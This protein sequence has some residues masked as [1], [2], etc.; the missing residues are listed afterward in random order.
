[1][2]IKYLG[3]REPF[4]KILEKMAASVEDHPTQ[5]IDLGGAVRYDLEY[6][7]NGMDLQAETIILS[8]RRIELNDLLGSLEGE[9]LQRYN[10]SILYRTSPLDIN[11]ELYRG[12]A[13]AT[14]KLLTAFSPKGVNWINS[15]DV[16]KACL[17]SKED[18]RSRAGKAFELT[19]PKTIS[20]EELKNIFESDL[21]MT[22]DM[23]CKS[24]KEITDILMQ[25]KMPFDVIEWLVNFQEQSSDIRLAP[26]TTMLEKIIGQKPQV[27]QLFKNKELA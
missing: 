4:K 25:N 7:I 11:I 3:I 8:N 14:G 22:I 24:K 18:I 23:Q 6:F 1:M 26:A 17:I 27:A 10:Q 5:I 2:I 13:G 12:W 9:L 21:E 19:G 16:A 15:K 20:M